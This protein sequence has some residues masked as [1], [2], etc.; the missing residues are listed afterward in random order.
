MYNAQFKGSTQADIVL[1]SVPVA[2]SDP[3]PHELLLSCCSAAIPSP[4]GRLSGQ[5]A[6]RL[7]RVEG[8]VDQQAAALEA[9]TRQLDK[10][11]IRS[12]LAGRDLKQPIQQ[13]DTGDVDTSKPL[14][15]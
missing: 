11:A 8:V 13:V 4:A 5:A 15:C 6:A 1:C 10:L 12:R 9:A 14:L 7:V 2:R 3:W